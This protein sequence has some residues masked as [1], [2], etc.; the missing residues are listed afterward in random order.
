VINNHREHQAP[1]S[2]RL[3]ALTEARLRSA[4]VPVPAA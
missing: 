4:G 3:T 2:A 1:V